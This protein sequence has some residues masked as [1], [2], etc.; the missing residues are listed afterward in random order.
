M[1]PHIHALNLPALC[2]AAVLVA[3]C[4]DSSGPSTPPSALTPVPVDS[5][6]DFSVYVTSPPGDH[7]RLIVV[8]RGGR[9]RLCKDGVPQDSAFLN[10]TTLT[11]PATG[12]YGIYSVAFHPQYATNHRLFV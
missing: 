11:S 4:G 1:R 9:I 6:Y 3:A 8:E 5:G 2:A 12:E 7:H 10:L